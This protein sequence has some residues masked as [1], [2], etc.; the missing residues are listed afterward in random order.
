MNLEAPTTLSKGNM[1]DIKANSQTND[2][3]PNQ[4]LQILQVCF[5]IEEHRQTP[6]K[7]LT[8][9]CSD[10]VYSDKFVLVND[11]KKR[12]DNM[13]PK[14]N[15]IITCNILLHKN[16][17]FCC[18]DFEIL[19]P[20]LTSKIGDPQPI[21]EFQFKRDD[22]LIDCNIPTSRSVAPMTS[23]N[24]AVQKNKSLESGQG[25]LYDEISFLT[26]YKSDFVIQARV[27]KKDPIRTYKNQRGDGHILSVLIMDNSG[28][29]KNIIKGTFFNEQALKYNEILEESKV[30]VFSGGEIKPKNARFNT[31][32]HDCEITFNRNTQI[33]QQA[34]DESATIAQENY[35][36]ELLP[37]I[38]RYEKYHELDV[39]VIVKSI[40]PIEE[41]NLRAGGTRS[42]RVAKVYDESGLCVELTIWGDI[43]GVH[44]LQEG[45]IV[46]IRSVIV[47]E[48]KGKCLSSRTSTSIS[49]DFPKDLQRYQSLSNFQKDGGQFQSLKEDTSDNVQHKVRYL[50]SLREI[51]N[52][53]EVNF[54]NMYDDERKKPIYFNTMA[55]VSYIPQNN[56]YY[57]A[58][59]TEKCAK[60]LLKEDDDQWRC[61]KCDGV[62]EKPQPRFIGKV[63]IM[64]HTGMNYCTINSEKVGKIVLGKSAEEIR[65]MTEGDMVD[66][67]ML[68]GHLK[69]RC[70][71]DYYFT[72]MARQE[73]WQGEFTTKLYLINAERGEDNCTKS[74]KN[75]LEN[76]EAYDKMEKQMAF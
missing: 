24:S 46:A 51:E 63:K 53:A 23:G 32:K 19:R 1:W 30:F 39:L 57:N 28:S 36:F 40:G 21:N 70:F 52:E 71:S 42:K 6:A 29:P 35:H 37:S 3:I 58:C 56:L 26:I 18:L 59:P 62:F 60:K 41:V 69:S 17:I 16:N 13:T 11:A 48:W 20:D 9:I 72:V 67:T 54:A 25:S 49:V 27:L 64:D 74:F 43:K 68:Q 66:E 55:T 8:F 44:L 31:T 15:D 61:Q 7:S 10:G 47:N 4:R 22:V 50:K 33:T 45:Q 14:T 5:D 65:E 12:I 38:E 75:L 73:S 34:D 76:I 2:V